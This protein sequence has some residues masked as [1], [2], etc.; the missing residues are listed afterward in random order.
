MN[1]TR[2]SAVP[3]QLTKREVA[4]I[5]IRNAIETGLYK[6]GQVISQ[7][8]I[9]ED[10]GLSVTPIR[11]AVL[12]M[13]GNGIVDRHKHHSIKVC[14]I[15]EKRLREIFSVRRILEQQAVRLA[16]A[17][18]T[19]EIIAR[20]D[21]L[22]RMLDIMEAGDDPATINPIDREFH[23]TIFAAAG[24]EALIWTIDKV[25]SSFPMYALW[26]ESGR[27]GKSV[28]EHRDLIEALG[29]GDAEASAEVQG[30]HLANGLDDLLIFLDREKQA[31][32]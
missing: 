25:K 21:R 17:N 28:A 30:R 3:E 13:M 29:A 16:A 23:Q 19:P 5:A 27:I 14:E 11:E 26:G 6:P 15:D 12:V 24:N 1:L 2:P 7:R 32:A 31:Q 4:E 9:A 18:M 20:L 8:Q 22:N 10:L